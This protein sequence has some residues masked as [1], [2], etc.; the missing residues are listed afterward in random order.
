MNRIALEE[1]RDQKLTAED[2]KDAKD[3]EVR[4]GDAVGAALRSKET[5]EKCAVE[6]HQE[7]IFL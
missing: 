7:R 6:R 3:A 2:A 5:N 1:G 4:R